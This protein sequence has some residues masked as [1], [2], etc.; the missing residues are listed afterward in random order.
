MSGW[1]SWGSRRKGISSP[2]AQ[3][4]TLGSPGRHLSPVDLE[5]IIDKDGN[6][7]DAKNLWSR[8]G[9]GTTKA[10]GIREGEVGGTGKVLARAPGTDLDL[11]G[12]T[13]SG[14]PPARGS[15]GAGEV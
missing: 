1:G 10:I 14:Q 3:A 5:G 6:Q 8:N 12:G 2:R 13:G 15:W 7:D 11:G 9:N 4:L